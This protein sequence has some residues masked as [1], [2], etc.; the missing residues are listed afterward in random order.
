MR[1]DFAIFILS[2]GRANNVKTVNTILREGYTGK[3]YII[4]DNEDSQ[5]QQYK[6]NFGCEHLLIFDKLVESKRSDTFDTIEQR[7]TV[8]FARNVCFDIAKKL[9]LKYFLELEDDYTIFRSRL[10]DGN[11][12]ASIEIMDMDSIILEMLEF[13][14]LSGALTVAFA[15]TGDLIGGIGSKVYKERLTRK[16]MNSFF[17]RVDRPFKFLG[18]MNDDVNAY[19]SLGS[20]GNLFFTIADITLEQ[21]GTQSN[22][23]GLTDMYLQF[24]T[25]VKSFYSVI[26]CPSCVKISDMGQT[27]KRIYHTINWE[28]TVP[29]IIS[30][31]FRK[32]CKGE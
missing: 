15:Q 28:N 22:K 30:D 23:G 4:C 9:N 3:W 6:N 24:G 29:K 12:L 13:L 11:K 1:E 31:R 7:N 2:N 14:D 5:L 19:T 21:G 32:D 18:R 10:Y 27:Q 8:L 25:Y 17:C 26:V 16:A 20:V